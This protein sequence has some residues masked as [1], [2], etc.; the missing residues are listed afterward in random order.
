MII[1]ELESHL[2]GAGYILDTI[3]VSAGDYLVILNLA[4]ADG[5]HEGKTCDVAIKRTAEN[6][7]V[8]DNCVHV[9]PH[10]VPMGQRSSQA[11]PV[12]GDWQYLSRRFDKTPTPKA[13]LTHLLTVLGEL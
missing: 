10:L 4:I 6:P 12:G 7:W 8:P 9:R 2:S 3:K 13:F 5:S 1:G 11:S